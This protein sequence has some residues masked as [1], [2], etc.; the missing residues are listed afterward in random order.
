VYIQSNE[1][2]IQDLPKGWGRG[3]EFTGKHEDEDEERG[4][5]AYNEGL[6]RSP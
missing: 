3:A 5:P 2:E 4:A 1:S 6:G